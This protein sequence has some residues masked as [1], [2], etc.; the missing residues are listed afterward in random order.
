MTKKV[1]DGKVN[2]NGLLADGMQGVNIKNNAPQN[3]TS[4]YDPD[5]WF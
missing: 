5:F 3:D 4:A 2:D 1:I